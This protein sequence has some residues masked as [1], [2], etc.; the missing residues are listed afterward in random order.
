MHFLSGNVGSD[1]GEV[2]WEH[3]G[4]EAGKQR[5]GEI[6]YWNSSLGLGLCQPDNLLWGQL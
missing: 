2:G 4:K 1:G 6:A 3:V 5:A